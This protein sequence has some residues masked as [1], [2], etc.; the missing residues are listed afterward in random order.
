M[1][2]P[3]VDR[4]LQ[5]VKTVASHKIAAAG[6][7]LFATLLALL[8]ANSSWSASY[9]GLVK[10]HVTVAVGSFGI[11]KSL[12]HWINDG[13]MGVFFFAVGLE[14]KREVLAGEFASLRKALLPAFAA[15]GGMVVPVLIY[16][17]INYGTPTEN[18]WG[19]PMATDIAFALGILAVLGNRVPLG[20]VLFL[21]GVA[22]VDDV[23][24]I[25]V[26]AIVYTDQVSLIS[27]LIGCAGFGLAL[28]ANRAGVRNP[29]VYLL[30]GIVVWVAFLK[31]G[32][33][34]TLAAVLM[35]FAIPAR[36]RLHGARLMSRV[37]ESL[38]ALRATGVPADTG[39]LTKD[40]HHAL[41]RLF[42]TVELATA[43]LQRLEILL[44]PFVKFFV[45]PLFALVNAGVLIGHGASDVLDSPVVLGTVAG[46]VVGK[47]VGIILFS[48]IAVRLN[49]A[50]L[51]AGASWRQI[52]GVGALAGIGF[53][54]SLF[55]GGLAFVDPASQQAAKMGILVAS[56]VSATVGLLLLFRPSRVA[57][58]AP[59][60]DTSS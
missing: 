22:I 32:V 13:L 18:G 31:S 56:L 44:A 3:V 4:I 53:T 14:I 2:L 59:G 46:L 27:L 16:L 49:L 43:P 7:L 33:H 50:D 17:A 5:P 60:Q 40:Q 39:L 26:I 9:A 15:V 28:V 48:W 34:A 42:E 52:H 54:M 35:A 41:G 36:T 10:T 45:L 30:F 23:G 29:V 19:I 1:P 51:P 55:I 24:A 12:L 8:W 37:S 58:S 57:T 38:D 21:T 11:S 20:L 47:P 25:L 6:A